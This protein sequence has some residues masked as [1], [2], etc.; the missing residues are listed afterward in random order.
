MRN[1]NII[2]VDSKGRVLIPIHIRKLM[3]TNEGT[4]MVI[5]PD[6]EKK[7]ARILPLIKD[8][9]AEFRM[10]MN[11][12][13]GSLAQ[14]ANIFVEYNIDIIMS[15]SRTLMRG[16]LAEWDIIADISECNGNIKQLKNTLLTSKLIKS[17]EL[18]KR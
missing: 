1:S 13:P 8:K 12:V 4:E 15:Q 7:Q 17:V 11:D 18:M 5:I 14:V 3:D 2:R 9:T 6:N 16:K 10:M